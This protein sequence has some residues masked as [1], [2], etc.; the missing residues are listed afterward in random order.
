MVTVI[1]CLICILFTS[2]QYDLEHAFFRA[3]DTNERTN[4]CY[5]ITASESPDASLEAYS[6][7]VFS[8]IHFGNKTVKQRHEQAFLDWLQET[9]ANGT[10]P[11]FCICLGDI[12]EHGQEEEFK[13]YNEF[14]A[15]VE[16]LL[17]SGKV[18][19]VLGN[20]DLFN[21]GWEDYKKLIFPYKSFYHFKTKQFS[22]YCLDT[23]SGTLG[24][25]QYETIKK[26]FQNDP[27][28][29]IILTHIPAY[30][31]PLNSMGYFSMQNT[32]EADLL[33]TL[34]SNSNVKL[35]LNGHI[36]EPYKNYFNSFLE[37]TAP[38]ITQTNSWTVI[39]IDENAG[40]ISEKM[41]FGK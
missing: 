20:H 37:L 26:M 11:A 12:A 4:T 29:K 39:S 23:A 19:N 30:S 16:A 7:A 17:G 13:A 5:T 9:K 33:L 10:A 24:R 36:H 2:C 18:Y 41:V 22:W 8:D 1:L 25:K 38:G 31:N 28:P 32:Y 6:V 3:G 14:V 21:N 40:T 27:S 34:Y 35:V 15:K